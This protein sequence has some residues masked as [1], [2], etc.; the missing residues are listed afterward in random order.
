MRSRI[1]LLVAVL[2]ASLFGTSALAA[3]LLIN[4]NFDNASSAPWVQSGMNPAYPIVTADAPITE[5]SAPSLAWL[6]GDPSTDMSITQDVAVP[7]GTASL[8]LS[9][10]RIIGTQESAPSVY[11]VVSIRLETTGGALL[12]ELATWNNTNPNGSWLAFSLPASGNYSGQTI[13]LRLRATNDD[14]Y[15]TN[16]FFDT[17]TLD[18][19][20]TA[21]VLPGTDGVHVSAVTPNPV[22]NEARLHVELAERS[23]LRADVL[24]LQGRRVRSLATGDMPAGGHD[25]VWDVT[26]G[27]AG[28]AEPGL[29]FYRLEIDGRVYTRAVA[30]V[31]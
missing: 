14:S 8:T 6:G 23:R 16:F 13:R 17:M 4:G 11:D 10:Y 22:R 7:S 3:N 27:G 15:V 25:L 9:G 30:V 26:R 1:V 24:D 19:V 31:R 20:P 18:A 29:Y 28:R 12:E 5:H 21:G 2:P